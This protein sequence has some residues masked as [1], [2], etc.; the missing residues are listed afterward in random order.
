[1]RRR[2]PFQLPLWLKLAV[3][4]IAGVVALALLGP[5]RRSM[6][7]IV[8]WMLIAAGTVQMIGVLAGSGRRG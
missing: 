6:V 4:V 3:V 2:K 1:V 8:S 5:D 7:E